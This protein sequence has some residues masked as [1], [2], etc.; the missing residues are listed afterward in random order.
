MAF[1]GQVR[2]SVQSTTLRVTQVFHALSLFVISVVALT[3]IG[4]AA[5]AALGVMPWLTLTA[6]FG[7]YSYPEAGIVVQLTVTA[8]LGLMLFFVPAS[9]RVLNLERA[10]RDFRVSMQDVARAFHL[11]HTADRAGLFT[12]SSEFDQVRERLAFLRDHPDMTM[13]ESDVLTLAAQMGQQAR[14]LADVYSDEKVARARAFLTERQTEAEAQQARILEAAHIV[15]EI[16][17]W[18]DQVETEEALVASQLAQLDEQLQSILPALGYGF[19]TVETEAE[20]RDNV[21][22]MPAA[23]SAAE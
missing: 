8:I 14:H 16:R 13:L 22:P 17:R 5:L 7:P 6:Q 2:V 19:E 4:I 9:V 20:P 15:R 12:L 10:H 1:R 18:A 11:A 21:V 23:K 3:A